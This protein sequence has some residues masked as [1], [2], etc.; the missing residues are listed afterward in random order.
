MT[1]LI[2]LLLEWNM[3]L[4]DFEGNLIKSVSV[5]IGTFV[6]WFIHINV[7]LELKK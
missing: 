2:A 4:L 1:L 3:G 7:M 6:V 5:L